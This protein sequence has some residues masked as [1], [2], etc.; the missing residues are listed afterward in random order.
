MKVKEWKC[1]V[2]SSVVKVDVTHAPITELVLP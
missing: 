2:C 1:S